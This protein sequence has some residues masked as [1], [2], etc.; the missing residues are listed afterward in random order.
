MYG[1]M[2]SILLVHVGESGVSTNAQSGIFSN[3]DCDDLNE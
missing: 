3:D 2:Q 1:L